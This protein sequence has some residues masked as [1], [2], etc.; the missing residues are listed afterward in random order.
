MNASGNI[1]VEWDLDSED[2]V[3]N[4]RLSVLFESAQLWAES[5]DYISTTTGYPCFSRSGKQSI[6]KVLDSTGAWPIKSIA[7]YMIEQPNFFSE[8]KRCSDEMPAKPLKLIIADIKKKI[9]KNDGLAR[10]VEKDIFT[11]SDLTSKTDLTFS[12]LSYLLMTA[13]FNQGDSDMFKRNVNLRIYWSHGP[14]GCMLRKGVSDLCLIED[15]SFMVGLPGIKRFIADYKGSDDFYPIGKVVPDAEEYFAFETPESRRDADHLRDIT[16]ITLI[17]LDRLKRRLESVS[18]DPEALTDVELDAVLMILFSASI[19]FGSAAIIAPFLVDHHEILGHR[20]RIEA[21]D[22]IEGYNEVV[23][24]FANQP[25]MIDYFGTLSEAYGGVPHV[26]MRRQGWPLLT[27]DGIEGDFVK[28]IAPLVSVI[29]EMSDEEVQFFTLSHLESN[30]KTYSYV[31]EI[32]LNVIECYRQYS[33]NE[34]EKIDRLVP[35]LALYVILFSA[36]IR[37]DHAYVN[38]RIIECIHKPDTPLYRLMVLHREH[39][40]DNRQAWIKCVMRGDLKLTKIDFTALPQKY[41]K[42]EFMNEYKAQM[43]SGQSG[44]LTTWLSEEAS[45]AAMRGDV[46]RLTE[47]SQLIN[48]IKHD[49]GEGLDFWFNHLFDETLAFSHLVDE[50]EAAIQVKDAPKEVVTSEPQMEDEVQALQLEVLS[51]KEQL[52]QSE[53]KANALK[54]AVRKQDESSPAPVVRTDEFLEGL[55]GRMFKRGSVGLNDILDYIENTVENV[56]VLDSARQNADQHKYVYTGKLAD[57]LIRLSTDYF[58]QIINGTPDSIAREALG[59]IYR[60]N[61]SDTTLSN[62]KWRNQRVFKLPD[63]E[64]ELFEQHMTLGT[65]RDVRYCIQVYFKIIEGTLYI[66]YIGPHLDTPTS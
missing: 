45:S 51:L 32:L 6:L 23:K 43:P 64:S 5:Q 4:D 29:R 59:G 13:L 50:I 24:P 26:L 62:P 10:F 66:G 22:L 61:E 8:F 18:D 20:Y 54:L 65:K 31:V 9:T 3:K 48:D 14:V 33:F 52:E 53:C 2:L 27:M 58:P 30:Y 7:R 38:D 25:S 56:V 11:P 44:D 46:Q 55:V 21:K 57:A 60:A 1:K 34:K 41:T 37:H 19:H 16:G 15:S 63:G 49:V 39:Y 35:L 42:L 47:V 28:G 17:V 36:Q 40:S 12:L